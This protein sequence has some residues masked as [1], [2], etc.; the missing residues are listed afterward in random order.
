MEDY[1][2]VILQNINKYLK[3]RDKKQKDLAE[4]LG[5]EPSAISNW[6]SKKNLFGAETLFKICE[7]LEVSAVELGG[8]SNYASPDERTIIEGYRA[9]VPQIKDSMLHQAKCSLK[10]T[11]EKG[12]AAIPS[13]EKS[14]ADIIIMNE[15]I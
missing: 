15:I 12:D 8:R 1:K 9:S 11:E 5:I 2:T 7:F 3:L 6:K 10:E 13:E 14:P 4:Y